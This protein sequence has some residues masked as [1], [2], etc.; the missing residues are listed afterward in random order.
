MWLL[1]QRMLCLGWWV[2][3]VLSALLLTACA[4]G[5]TL[6][7]HAFGFDA[8]AD[9]PGVQVLDYRYG[10]SRAPGAR[11][12]DWVKKD[13]GVA[14]GTHTRGPM[15]VGESLYVRWRLRDTGEEL[16]DTVDLRG[17]LPADMAGHEIYFIVRARQL[18][19]YLVSPA[20]MG[21]GNV[22]AGMEKFRQHKVRLIYPG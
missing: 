8:V 9:S 7:D 17:R 21:P 6:V 22:V 20:R 19:V 5:P 14:G 4:S 3:I 15:A 16:Q 18:L 11:M 1:G 12:P 2:G 10:P 13:V